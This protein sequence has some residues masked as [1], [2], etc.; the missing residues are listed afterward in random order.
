MFSS[1]RHLRHLPSNI[2]EPPTHLCR[3]KFLTTLKSSSSI[4][5]TVRSVSRDVSS[6]ILTSFISC[7]VYSRY[8]G[9]YLN[10]QQTDFLYRLSDSRI[11]L[12]SRSLLSSFLRVTVS[13]PQQIPIKQPNL[14]VLLGGLLFGFLTGH[15]IV[16]RVNGV[17]CSPSL[18][19][20]PPI[21]VF[22]HY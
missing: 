9:T 16:V 18:K 20:L 7:A 3:R 12:T 10:P 22:S 8:Q 11:F 1:W 4:L 5:P 2:H 14:R 19:V 6:H 17:F 15:S 21:L 13:G